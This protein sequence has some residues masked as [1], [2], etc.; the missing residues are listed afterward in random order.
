MSDPV[1]VGIAFA[2]ACFWATWSFINS[3]KFRR[4]Q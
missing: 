2:L 4:K 3:N 1:W